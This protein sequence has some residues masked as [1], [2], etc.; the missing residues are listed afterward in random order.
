MT[1][2]RL[3]GAALA[4]DLRRRTTAEIAVLRQAGLPAP[5]LDVVL[6]GE[7]AASAVYVGRKARAC[8]EVGI[9]SKV[10]RRPAD[11]GAGEILDL[12]RRLSADAAV[13]G[14]LVQLPLPAAIDAGPILEAVD[15][16]KDV[17]G[18]HPV[19]A[20]AL[21]LG[22]PRV[23]PC[24][25]AGILALLHAADVAV[26]GTRAVVLGRSRIVGRP[27]ALLLVNEN[28]TVT[29]AH[30]RTQDVAALCRTADLLVVAVG[31]PGLVTPAFVR[32]GAV[33]VDVGMHRLP[34]P[35]TRLVGDVDP[36]VAGVAGALTPV[37]GG[38]GPLTV[39]ML[40]RN[41]VDAWRRRH[42]R[43]D[44]AAA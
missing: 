30:S 37:P 3:D 17:D 39:A 38:V 9:D 41:T 27:M 16:D 36:A 25:P 21:A 43:T 14:I 33:V 26:A 15:P 11:A 29:I 44:P 18:F 10:H 34:G 22:R 24:T 4:A 23:V 32:P 12:V 13:D 31:R 35:D 7:D 19:N 28:A 40:L 42:G 20:G 5:R 6:V 1:A 2:R 8:A